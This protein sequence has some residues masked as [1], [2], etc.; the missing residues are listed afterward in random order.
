MLMGK[1]RNMKKQTGFSLIGLMVGMVIGLIVLGGVVAMFTSTIS[2]STDTVNSTRMNHDLN[3][4][5][6]L[7]VN[8]IRRAGYWGG[9]VAGSNANNEAPNCADG[10]PFT[11]GN[12]NI[13]ITNK[14]GENDDSCILYTYDANGNGINTSAATEPAVPRNNADDIDLDEYF[15]FRISGD[16]IEMRYSIAAVADAGNCNKGTWRNIA[17]NNKVIIELLTF[18]A[19]HKCL[20][21]TKGGLCAIE[22]PALGDKVVETRQI[23][24]SLKGEVKYDDTAKKSLNGSV[25]VRNDRIFTKS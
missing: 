15:G 22:T 21:V 1:R 25:K 20:N 19:S 11:C 18:T 7:M 8:D 2:S 24:I 23:D 13:K 16:G 10:N 12:A 9:A 6:Q 4:V 14:T 5:M 17:D 3:S